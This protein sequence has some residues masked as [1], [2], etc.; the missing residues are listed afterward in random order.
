MVVVVY[1]NCACCFS[2]IFI[3]VC[4]FVCVCV[5]IKSMCVMCEYPCVC[6]CVFVCVRNECDFCENKFDSLDC[7][8]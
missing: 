6:F 5:Y 2:L 3:V 8:L 1:L 7:L 4:V